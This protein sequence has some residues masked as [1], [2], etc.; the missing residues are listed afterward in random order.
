MSLNL[1]KFVMTC[2]RILVFFY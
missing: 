2:K 1:L